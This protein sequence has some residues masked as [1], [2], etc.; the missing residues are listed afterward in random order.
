[1]STP[2]FGHLT[3]KFL[4]EGRVNS[5]KA[6]IPVAGEKRIQSRVPGEDA[7]FYIYIEVYIDVYI[8]VDTLR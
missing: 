8:G 5:F 4:V 7:R 2:P 3:S 1:M 6:R